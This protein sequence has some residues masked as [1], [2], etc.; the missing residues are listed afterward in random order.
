MKRFV[1]LGAVV[2][3]ALIL[4]SAGWWFVAGQA[5]GLVLSLAEADG[6][7]T[8]KLTCTDISVAGYPFQVNVDCTQPVLIHGDMRL[9][10]S[11]LRAAV[12]VYDPKH[13]LVFAKSPMTI[14]DAFT[15]SRQELAWTQL[16]AS[17][18]LTDW[19]IG[20]ISIV[21]DGLR[22]TDALMGD[23]LL[24]SIGHAELHFLDLPEAHDAQEH[25]A[26]LHGYL[27]L[28]EVAAPAF[29]IGHGALDADATLTGLP[30]DVRLYR[31]RDLLRR[32]QKA[33][34]EL[35]LNSLDARDGGNFVKVEGTLALDEAGRPK[36]RVTVTSKGL[37]E[38]LGHFLPASVKA[39]VL[40][41]PAPDGS[42]KQTFTLTNGIVLD[43]IVPVAQVPSLF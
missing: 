28:E 19:R 29:G 27:A 9:S 6:V 42:Y 40:G 16:E 25:R 43:G 2:A 37:A 5:R 41:G 10:M 34:G 38:R 11:D 20:R 26:G 21:G 31:G 35:A 8:P 30:D 3:L 39:L 36:G 24:A 17:V 14:S 7:S 22:L 33:G 23:R 18:R 13:A 15:G 12:V 32:V 4:W 1:F